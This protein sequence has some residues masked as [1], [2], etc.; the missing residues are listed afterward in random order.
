MEQTDK[1]KKA[2][3]VVRGEMGYQGDY[4]VLRGPYGFE[5][6]ITEPEDRTF[7]RD[8]DG[9]VIE[10]NRLHDQLKEC[11]EEIDWLEKVN[12]ARQQLCVAYRIGS[13]S[14]AD[15]ALTALEKLGV[16]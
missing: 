14:V 7:Y 2:Y 8:L 4:E 5:C 6:V 9:M 10:L 3:Y 13:H 12:K 1:D 15:K 16:K 11:R